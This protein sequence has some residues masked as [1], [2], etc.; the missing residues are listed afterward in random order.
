MTIIANSFFWPKNTCLAHAINT[1]KVATEVVSNCFAF[2]SKLLK[3]RLEKNPAD[4][5]FILLPLDLHQHNSNY[6]YQP[7][8]AL[9]LDVSSTYFRQTTCSSLLMCSPF[10]S[11]RQST[12]LI[13]TSAGFLGLSTNQNPLVR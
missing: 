6:P 1:V 13:A 9:G 12:P 2:N 8:I 5:S 11:Y 7:S 3:D 4:F 10:K